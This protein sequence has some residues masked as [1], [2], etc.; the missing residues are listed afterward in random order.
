MR[1]MLGLCLSAGLVAGCGSLS[2]VAYCDSFESELC[3]RIFECYTP[4]MKADPT[5][6]PTFGASQ[7]DC[8]T[9][10]K[11]NNC[12]TVTNDRPCPD[13][14][15]KYHSDK[16]EACVHDLKAA[17]CATVVNNAFQSDNCDTICS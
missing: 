3:A 6:A 17:D 10:L 8:E 13:S 11:M 1:L 14:M 16:A 12:T 15:T 2:P 5:F 4:E 9:K 7:A